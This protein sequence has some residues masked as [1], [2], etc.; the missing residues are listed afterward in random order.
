MI[1]GLTG[2]KRRGKDTVAAHLVA[3]HDFKRYGFADKV[4]AY[5]YAIN[6]IIYQGD[7]DETRY[8]DL[9]DDMG[10]EAAKEIPE[11]RAL[12][13]RTGTEAGRSIFWKDF[14]VDILFRQLEEDYM[15]YNT[16]LD[17]RRLQTSK[18][19]VISD[20]RFDNE[21]E[22][23]MQYG[24]HVIRVVSSREGL[25]APDD[26]ASEKDIASHLISGTIHNNGSFEELYRSI[27]EMLKTLK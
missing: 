3:N 24:G 19:I 25:P 13:Q 18:G 12:L 15:A 17:E 10:I 20:V 11:I 16:G 4:K 23:I 8:Q 21:A 1:I 27:D 26:H 5:L 9:V 2:K 6:P 22:R 7:S 14:W